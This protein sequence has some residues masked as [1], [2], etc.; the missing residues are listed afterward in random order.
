[1]VGSNLVGIGTYTMP[2][3]WRLH[4]NFKTA[5]VGYTLVSVFDSV[6]TQVCVKQGFYRD[7]NFSSQKIYDGPHQAKMLTM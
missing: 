2:A 3:V 4:I 5:Y 7:L 1:M 6:S